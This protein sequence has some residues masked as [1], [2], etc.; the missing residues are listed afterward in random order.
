ML[1]QMQEHGVFR[2]SWGLLPIY[3]DLQ[4]SLSL[5]AYAGM[6][7]RVLSLLSIVYAGRRQR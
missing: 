2:Y 3:S 6:V 4:G 7:V 5:A 1:Q